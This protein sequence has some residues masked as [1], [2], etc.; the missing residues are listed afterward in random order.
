MNRDNIHVFVNHM[1]NLYE[2]K[3]SISDVEQQTS[4]IVNDMNSV[5]E[6]NSLIETYNK[7]IYEDLKKRILELDSML[8]K[9]LDKTQ[10]IDQYINTVINTSVPII[11][12]NNLDATIVNILQSDDEDSDSDISEEYE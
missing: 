10:T 5:A 12:D 2:T 9:I 11:V 7:P 6:A 4:Q 3:K 8:S 1:I